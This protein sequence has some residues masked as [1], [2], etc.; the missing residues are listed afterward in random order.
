MAVEGGGGGAA[1]AEGG[2]GAWGGAE[3]KNGAQ[4]RLDEFQSQLR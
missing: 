4:L 2:G 3:D 1:E